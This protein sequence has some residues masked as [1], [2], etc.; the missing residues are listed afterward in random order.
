MRL[1][2]C[3]NRRCAFIPESFRVVPGILCIIPVTE[4][5]M[6][7]A[8]NMNVQSVISYY[9]TEVH[10]VHKNGLLDFAA[11]NGNLPLFKILV[12]YGT[13]PDNRTL[14]VAIEHNQYN[15]AEYM[16]RVCRVRFGAMPDYVKFL[17]PK[18]HALLSSYK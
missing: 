11:K 1:C 7:I 5:F 18:I 16:L 3:I 9:A 8:C 10:M 15:M 14:L 13:I 6:H 4:Y 2:R 12:E 17:F